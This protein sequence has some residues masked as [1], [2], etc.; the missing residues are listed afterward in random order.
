MFRHPRALW[1]FT[2]HL[3]TWTS[4]HIDHVTVSGSLQRTY[5]KRIAVEDVKKQPHKYNSID[6]IVV[7]KKAKDKSI[8]SPN[9]HL[10]STRQKWLKRSLDYFRS[11]ENYYDFLCLGP[12]ESELLEISRQVRGAHLDLIT[13][14]EVFE[15]ANTSEQ[16]LQAWKCLVTLSTNTGL[17]WHQ[18]GLECVTE[19]VLESVKTCTLDQLCQYVHYLSMVHSYAPPMPQLLRNLVTSLDE[20]SHHRLLEVISRGD[21]VDVK[22]AIMHLAHC[23]V[24]VGMVLK[25]NSAAWSFKYLHGVCGLLKTNMNCL[26]SQ[27]F[28][29]VM[30]LCGL[31]RS[32]TDQVP[33]SD[34]VNH[35]VSGLQSWDTTAIGI[36][37]ETLHKNRIK[38]KELPEE[39]TRLLIAT[40][41]NIDATLVIKEDLNIGAICKL[42]S[43]RKVGELF[44]KDMCRVASKFS[45]VLEFMSPMS[46]IRLVNLFTKG[47]QNCEPKLAQL[48]V[49]NIFD[50]V[51][52]LRIK[53]IETI[54]Q[55][56]HTLNVKADVE[57]LRSAL[58]KVDWSDPRSGRHLIRAQCYLSKMGLVDESFLNTL[59]S[60]A[61]NQKSLKTAKTL[62]NFTEAAAEFTFAMSETVLEG[63]ELEYFQRREI[64]QN[65]PLLLDILFSVAT[66]DCGIEIE[67][68]F[69][70]GQRLDSELRQRLLTLRTPDSSESFARRMR[71]QICNTTQDIAGPNVYCTRLIPHSQTEDIVLCLPDEQIKAIG[72]AKP[73]LET[74]SKEITKPPLDKGTWI[75]IV[76][77]K[78][79]Q[80]DRDGHPLGPVVHHVK[81][82]KLLGY[83]VIVISHL[84]KQRRKFILKEIKS[85]LSER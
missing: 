64:D 39:V 72:V 75:A 14:Q 56:C 51:A 23:W 34:F 11:Q 9:Y 52:D 3:T 66:L 45:E 85:I 20:Q 19:K 28:L 10:R 35:L 36:S 82:L 68:P 42:L 12:P 83:K 26:T 18:S 38:L 6:D 50:S 58:D 8:R 31:Q 44:E 74:M 53:D 5:S 46:Q 49:E 55:I 13:I 21:L 41:L 2:R 15:E 16:V 54:C 33:Q 7:I 27:D 24:K 78:R 71:Q 63:E 61:N 30:F 25:P 22:H 77:P 40:L 59:F 29:Y 43:S 17:D 60:F 47:G 67:A 81:Q 4:V 84:Q 37:A 76:T 32:F 69:Y 70:E 57:K 62:S 65:G 80:V 48:L 73:F 79:G 1:L